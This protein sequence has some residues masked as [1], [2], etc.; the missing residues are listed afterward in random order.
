MQTNSDR[1]KLVKL[2]E[3]IAP[4]LVAGTTCKLNRPMRRYR[5]QKY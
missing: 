5:L 3:G 2:K 1:K 4:Y